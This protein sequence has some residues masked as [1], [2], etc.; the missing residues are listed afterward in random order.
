MMNCPPGL[1]KVHRSSCFFW[2]DT[3]HC[4][5][6]PLKVWNLETAICLATLSIENPVLSLAIASDGATVVAGDGDGWVHFLQI[7][8]FES[9]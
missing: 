7:K 3:C 2:R 5:L 4:D 6:L 1:D 8:A 9:G